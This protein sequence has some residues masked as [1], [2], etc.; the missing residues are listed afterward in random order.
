MFKVMYDNNFKTK[1]ANEINNL[2]KY[3]TIIFNKNE[4]KV[5]RNLCYV[6][7]S[8]R[9]I[10]HTNASKLIN[11]EIGDTCFETDPPQYNVLFQYEDGT[12]I[13]STDVFTK[14]KI[15]QLI[16]KKD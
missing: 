15:N 8:L 7:M 13:L 14:E 6:G 5:L 4:Y 9:N 11:I 16:T 3:E 1:Y 12:N 10:K 2:L